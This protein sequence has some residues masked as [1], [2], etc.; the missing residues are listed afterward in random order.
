MAERIPGENAVIPT[1]PWER[2]L[3][4]I[5]LLMCGLWNLLLLGPVVVFSDGQW[6]ERELIT[7]IL[8]LGYLIFDINVPL[9]IVLGIRFFLRRP[10][11]VVMLR[12][13]YGLWLIVGSGMGFVAL[14]YWYAGIA[15]LANPY[16]A[17]VHPPSWAL[18]VTLFLI[19]VFVL[20]S[21]LLIV[22][23]V[24]DLWFAFRGTRHANVDSTIHRRE[25]PSEDDEE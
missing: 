4:F 5:A 6:S 12:Q 20:G 2:R 21:I 8:Q 19:F 24:H 15:T 11:Y 1:P 25:E 3:Q 17:K 13:A 18:P 14:L 10:D 16:N 23:I 7:P 22:Q 9:A